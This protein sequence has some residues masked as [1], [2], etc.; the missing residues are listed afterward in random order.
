MGSTFFGH[1]THQN[2]KHFHEVTKE[3]DHSKLYQISMD[4]LSVNLKFYNEIVQDRQENMVHLLI[5][6]DSCSLHIFHCSFKTGAEKPG[7]NLKTLLKG[8]FKILHDT[9]AR[10]EDY[11]TVT[12]SSKYPL[13]FCATRRI[14]FC[15]RVFF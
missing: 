15:F 9:P 12:G 2:L 10:R 1:G 6:I 4:G 3:L 8:S 11:E 14:F 7:W 13:F 5:D